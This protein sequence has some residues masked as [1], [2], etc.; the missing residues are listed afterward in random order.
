MSDRPATFVDKQETLETAL[1]ELGR[2]RVLGVDTE[3][4]SFFVYRERTC[5][6][7]VSS[8]GADYVFDPISLDIS[9]LMALLANPDIEKIFH[10]AE[11]DVV[12]LR[13]DYGVAIENLYDTSIAARAT[14]H[15][16]IGLGS[17]VEELL[18]IKLVK[19]EQ[20][21]DWGRRPLTK[22][23][24]A[25]AFADTRHLLALA[26]A[27]K[28]EV[29]A[30]G[31]TE[32]VAVDCERV[33]R[34]EA[35]PRAFDPESFERHPSARKLDP[36]SRRLLRELYLAREERAKAL[37]KPPFR[38]ASD[39]AL[40]E[41][42][43]RKAATKAELFGIPGLTPGVLARHGAA[44]L[45]AVQRGLEAGPLPYQKKPFTPPDPLEE[46]RYER[47]R[48]WRRQVAEA[49]GVEVEPVAGNAA[50]RALAKANPTS[51]EALAAVEELDGYRRGK[52][53]EAL[54]ALL[55]T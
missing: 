34:R 6:V 39:Q 17:M 40:G 49:R 19:D 51:L 33:R 13:R 44:L 35:R 45:E 53:G 9:P 22:E 8:A 27:L 20:R 47:L 3:A 29:A 43:A 46:E 4:N 26:Q 15:K 24:V 36:L 5:L 12:S 38:I 1:G 28:L 32:E 30:K 31:L 11:F 7:Q 21:S 52:Y 14:G 16:K 55:A 18:D 50:L 2:E 37:D 48:A 54:L 42:A 41:V 10:A 25:Y 23:Q